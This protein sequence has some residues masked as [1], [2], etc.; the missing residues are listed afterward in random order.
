MLLD[1][2]RPKSR[3]IK[4]AFDRTLLL[5]SQ[6]RQRTAVSTE[7]K[8]LLAHNLAV[9]KGRTTDICRDQG[10]VP[11]IQTSPTR[12]SHQIRLCQV[13][14]TVMGGPRNLSVWAENGVLMLNTC[15]TVKANQAGSHAGKGWED[16][17]DK[18]VDVVDKY[19]GANL[20][21]RNDPDARG[22][23]RGVVFLAWGAWAGKRVA[24]L[25]KVRAFL[26]ASQRIWN[27]MRSDQAP[28]PHERGM[29]LALGYFSIS[30]L[31]NMEIAPL[32]V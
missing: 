17:T 1:R 10:R 12:V 2:S 29:C 3:L 13:L 19:G 4:D 32:A 25:N 23:G 26:T 22:I 15:L 27:M 6:G 8:L 7:R 14:K 16:F 31:L 21:G 24:R 20:A 11:R 30:H 18:V 28:D 5:R 9:T